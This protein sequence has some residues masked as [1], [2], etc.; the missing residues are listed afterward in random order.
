MKAKVRG[1]YS[2][3][4]TK[5]LLDNGFKIVQ[6]SLTTKNRFKLSENSTQPDI[7]LKDRYDLQ[8]I[9]VIGTSDAVNAFQKI[10]Q[11]T[12]LDVIT[13]KWAVSVDG[14]YKGKVVESNEHTIYVD[15]GGSVIGRLQ[16]SESANVKADQ[17]LV[18]VER[19]RIWSRQPVLTTDLKVI[20]DH[21]ILMQNC[22]LGVSLKIR[23]LSKRAKLYALGKILAPNGWGIIW[24][25]S[26]AEQSRETLGNEIARLVEK[27]K[28]L[29]E[30]ASSTE[31]PALLVEG[32]YFMDVEFPWLSKNRMDQLRASATLTLGRHH[33]YK[34]CGGKVSAALEMAEKLLEKGQN[35]DEVETLFKKQILYEFAE[36]G[37]IIDVEHVKLSGLVFHLG[38]ATIESFDDKQIRYSRIM[39]SSGMYDGLGTRKEAGDKAKS[40]TKIGEWYVTTDYCSN[41]GEWKGSYVNLNTPI[42]VYPKTIRYV[43]LEVDVCI[44]PKGEVSIL[45]MEKLENALE[46]G[47][48]SES[49]FKTV[50][51]K[52]NE[53]IEAKRFNGARKM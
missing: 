46:E 4:L 24:R 33:F 32:S 1:I 28:T 6:P 2:T 17:L 16:K 35:L 53:I 8:G 31:A 29:A 38:E 36:T 51:E 20:G 45:D 13:R 52:A 49:L 21:A 5:L 43:D 25:E 41:S 37:S 44:K 19:Y 42:E 47:F 22:K 10:L 40:V 27:S 18:Q 48:I 3:A 14:I 11:F 7:T 15:L 26:S 9:K 39:R 50:K 12:F 34:S 30:K 23:D